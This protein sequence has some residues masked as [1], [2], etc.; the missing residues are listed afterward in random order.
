MRRG[1]KLKG[2]SASLAASKA[3]NGRAETKVSQW[4]TKLASLREGGDAER[5]TSARGR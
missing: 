2:L 1:G 5:P 3:A 4:E